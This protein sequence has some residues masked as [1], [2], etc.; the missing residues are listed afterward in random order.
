MLADFVLECEFHCVYSITFFLKN[1]VCFLIKLVRTQWK[2]KI[3]IMSP[4]WTEHHVSF[5]FL[6]WSSNPQEDG[7]LVV[8]PLGSN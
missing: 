8:V 2:L 7:Y 3:T 4:L 6:C 1:V 5:K